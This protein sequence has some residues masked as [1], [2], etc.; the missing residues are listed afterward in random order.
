[1]FTS[2]DA[3]AIDQACADACLAATPIAKNTRLEEMPHL[4]KDPFINSHPIS[5]WR[6]QL[7]HGE[8]IA[9]GQRDYELIGMK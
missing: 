3:V 4:G 7:I 5:E 2:F 1:M 6:S 9:L 8:K